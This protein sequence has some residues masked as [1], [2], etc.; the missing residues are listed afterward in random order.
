MTGFARVFSVIVAFALGCLASVGLWTFW[1]P[2]CMDGCAG[3]SGVAMI[4][5]LAVFPPLCAGLA[6]LLNAVRWPRAV[7]AAVLAGALA[8]AAGVVLYLGE[9]V[10]SAENPGTNPAGL[11]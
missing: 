9:T 10:G 5:F 4:V 1:T 6:V 7:K 8:V 11:R 2:R 3:R